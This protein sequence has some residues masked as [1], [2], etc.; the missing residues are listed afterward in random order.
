LQRFDAGTFEISVIVSRR[1]AKVY[2]G[3]QDK[4]IGLNKGHT[5]VQSLKNN[6]YAQGNQRE[7]D[8]R[9][10]LSR[11]HVCK[12]T[13]GQ[14]QDPR[15]MTEYLDRKHKRGQPPDRPYEV[16]EISGA[17]FSVDYFR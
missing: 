6:R 8:E 11:K 1:F 16:L 17:V 15:Q 7:K 4:N 3:K 5:N 12:E 2:A 14:R 10:H 9:D 13:D